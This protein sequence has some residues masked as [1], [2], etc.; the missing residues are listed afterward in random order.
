M[1]GVLAAPEV[2][3]Q[4]NTGNYDGKAVDVWACGVMLFVMLFCQYPFERPEDEQEKIQTKRYQMVSCCLLLVPG[5]QCKSSQKALCSQ[6]TAGLRSAFYMYKSPSLLVIPHGS[7]L[8]VGALVCPRFC[9]EGTL[10]LLMLWPVGCAAIAARDS[11]RLQDPLARE[12][13]GPLPRPPEPH[14]AGQRGQAH[15][16]PRDPQARVVCFLPFHMLSARSCEAAQ[17]LQPLAV[18]SAVA[19]TWQSTDRMKCQ[20]VPGSSTV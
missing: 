19:L 14:P 12:D 8:G 3:S 2:I 6:S 16:H 5:T 10:G 11:G 17:L 15:H 13:L 1:A 18:V 4:G 9:L 20:D 7:C